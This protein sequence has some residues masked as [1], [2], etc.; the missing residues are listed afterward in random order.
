MAAWWRCV[1][2]IT[3]QHVHVSIT[4]AAA[5]AAATCVLLW[6]M[7]RTQLLTTLNEQSKSSWKLIIFLS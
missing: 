3:T 4:A 2:I 1:D 6:E 5:A 7:L